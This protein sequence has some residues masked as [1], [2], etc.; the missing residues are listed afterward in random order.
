MVRRNMAKSGGGKIPAI[1]SAVLAAAIATAVFISLIAT[2]AAAQSISL[3]PA[4]KTADQG[5]ATALDLV[6]NSAPK[7]LAGH[8]INVSLSG[9]D[10][11]EIIEVTYILSPGR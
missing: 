5:S 3:L 2:G 11:A 4:D 1:S 8:E 9:P 7:G 6:R 10:K